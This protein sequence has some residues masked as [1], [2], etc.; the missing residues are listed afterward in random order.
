[1]LKGDD[2]TSDFGGKN[3]FLGEESSKNNDMLI[4]MRELFLTVT[5]YSDYSHKSDSL[6]Q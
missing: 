2:P 4:S 3:V 1:M 6:K 5:V